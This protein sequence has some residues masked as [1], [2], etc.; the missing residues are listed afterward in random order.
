MSKTRFIAALC[1]IAFLL[2]G[3]AAR[4]EDVYVFAAASATNALNDIGTLFA[5][6]GLGTLK[7][8][9]ASS[10]TLAKQV[11][12]GAPAQIFL[13]ADQQW[14]DYLAGKGLIDKDSR[15][16]LLGNVLVLVVPAESKVGPITIGKD[17]DFAKLLGEGRLSTGDPDHVPVGLYLR[18]ALE[19]LGQWNAVEPRLARAESVRAALALVERGEAPYGVVYATDALVSPK[20]RI[21]A[22]FPESLHDPVVYPVALVA[23]KQSPAAKAFF[24][25][26]KSNE[27][28]GVFARYGFKLN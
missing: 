16:N 1:G 8:S 5:A 21:V 25:F 11:E 10:S 13:S 27:A 7:A 9:Y 3:A 4:A 26:L 28:K 15:T 17:T 23:G 12:Q 20:V 24:E 22:T 14:M 18:Q 2:A 6:K 19:K